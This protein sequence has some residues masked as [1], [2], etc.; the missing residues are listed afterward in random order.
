M[1][2]FVGFIVQSNGFHFPWDL[3]TS[4]CADPETA[5]N[6][7]PCHPRGC[8]ARG[9]ISFGDIS[10]AG[11]PL[12]QWDALPTNAKLQIIGARSPHAH[13]L[14]TQPS[15]PSPQRLLLSSL[16]PAIAARTRR[17]RA[18][19]LAAQAW[20]GSLS[21]GARTRMRWR[22]L[23]RSTT[24]AAASPASSRRSTRVRLK[25]ALTFQPCLLPPATPA[26]AIWSPGNIPHPV[27]LELFDPFGLSKNASPEKK[28]KGL[29]AEINNGRLAM[30]GIMA[31]VA[32][33]KVP[34]AVP[35]LKGLITPYSGECMA[36]FAASDSLPFV[37]AACLKRPPAITRKRHLRVLGCS[38]SD[39][40]SAV[41]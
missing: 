35:A 1:A 14:A 10:A 25:P 2:A 19:L 12:A 34:G 4:G 33:A 16:S 3:T 5:S 24:C 7:M 29:L 31:F 26:P 22:S 41:S 30:L 37:S 11:S 28:E 17:H 32:E 20:S 39:A 27:P 15:C 21:G 8:A 23:A 13:R 18:G 40:R 36:P 38:F 6:L 9:R